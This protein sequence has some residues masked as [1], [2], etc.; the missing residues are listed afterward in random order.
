MAPCQALVWPGVRYASAVFFSFRL[1][2]RAT[3][4]KVLGYKSAK[5]DLKFVTPIRFVVKACD[6]IVKWLV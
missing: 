2:G 5:A 1:T 4:V 6:N 3:S